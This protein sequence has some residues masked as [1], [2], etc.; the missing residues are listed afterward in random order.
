MP[1]LY[2][3]TV[4]IAKLNLTRINVDTVKGTSFDKLY[5]ESGFC[6]RLKASCKGHKLLM[7]QIIIHGYCHTI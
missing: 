2:G 5:N 7:P 6:T 3:I 4:L 1:I